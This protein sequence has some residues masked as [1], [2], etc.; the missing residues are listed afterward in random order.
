MRVKT[1]KW[2]IVRCGQGPG[3]GGESIRYRR[4]ARRWWV[5]MLPYYYEQVVTSAPWAVLIGDGFT[6]Y[7]SDCC[8]WS[9]MCHDWFMYHELTLVIMHTMRHVVMQSCMWHHARTCKSMISGQPEA[10]FTKRLTPRPHTISHQS[11]GWIPVP[12]T[13]ARD[14]W[15]PELH[16]ITRHST[17]NQT[18]GPDAWWSVLHQRAG[19]CRNPDQKWGCLDERGCCLGCWL[20]CRMVAWRQVTKWEEEE[21]GGLKN[22]GVSLRTV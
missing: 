22:G 6:W 19:R 3:S 7:F 1:V 18:T 21:R 15:P 11:P 8:R 20:Q 16:G 10:C 14:H 4:L 12:K 2:E 17:D 9:C 5:Y 13:Q